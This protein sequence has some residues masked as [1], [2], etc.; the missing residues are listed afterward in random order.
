V[1]DEIEIAS[2]TDARGHLFEVNAGPHDASDV[3]AAVAAVLPTSGDVSVWVDHPTD[4]LNG[5]LGNVGLEV[6]RDLYKMAVNLPLATSSSI[7][8]RPFS[9]GEDEQ[10]WMRVNNRAFSW[11]REQSDWTLSDVDD[12]MAEPWFDAAG[13]L[14]HEDEGQLLGFC[15]TKLHLDLTPPEGEIYVIAVDPDGQGRGL[16]RELTVAGLESIHARGIANGILYVD[17]DNTPAVTLYLSLG[18]EIDTVRRLYVN[19]EA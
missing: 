15:W 11:H 10:A 5:A 2:G 6:Q 3:A 17:A 8:T 9:P 18:F 12:R 13:F 14:L 1:S 16:G 7:D 19:Q 4:V